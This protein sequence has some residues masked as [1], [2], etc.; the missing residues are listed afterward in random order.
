MSPL[1]INRQIT[2]KVR[3]TEAFR[4][5]MAAQIQEAIKKLERETAYLETQAKRVGNNPE[6][7]RSLGEE[8][9]ARSEKRARLTEEL[10]ELAR[11]E[12]GAEVVQGSVNGPVEVRIGDDW[13]RLMAAEIVLEDGRVV[14]IRE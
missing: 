12:P 2:V 9:Q 14:A 6:V 1:T 10:K 5:A 8:I 7:A 3:V 11:L 13:A 4:K